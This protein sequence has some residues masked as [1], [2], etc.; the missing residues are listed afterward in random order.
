MSSSYDNLYKEFLF[1]NDCD[2]LS[3]KDLIDDQEY[4]GDEEDF[5]E[6]DF[7]SYSTW[8]EQHYGEFAGSYAQ[9]VRGLSDEFINDV[10]D[11]DPELYWNID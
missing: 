3:M 6:E 5:Y 4:F 7:S 1:E 8:D 9:D 2:A 11:G 10:L